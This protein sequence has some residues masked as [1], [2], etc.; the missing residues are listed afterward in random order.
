[1]VHDKRG[2]NRGQINWGQVAQAYAFIAVF[3]GFAD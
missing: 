3:F 1:M 2:N